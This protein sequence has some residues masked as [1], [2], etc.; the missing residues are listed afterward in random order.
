LAPATF[1]YPVT[2]T[3]NTLILGDVLN[4]GKTLSFQPTV[5]VESDNAGE[6]TRWTLGG[7]FTAANQLFSFDATYTFTNPKGTQLTL[8]NALSNQFLD[9]PAQNFSDVICEWSLSIPNA[10]GSNWK[11]PTSQILTNLNEM[12]FRL[13]LSTGSYHYRNTSAPPS[14]QLFA[15]EQQTNITV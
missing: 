5:Y 4:S 11:D 7:I 1:R 13:S 3:N 12:A 9:S 8:P 14:P 15:M 10:C 6:G 2:I